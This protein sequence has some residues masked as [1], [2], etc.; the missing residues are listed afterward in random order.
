MKQKILILTLILLTILT[1][2]R[3][4]IDPEVDDFVEYGWTLY[5]ARDFRGALA[6]FQ[7]GL[8]LD[9]QYIDGYNGAGWCY[10]EFNSPDTAITYFSQGLDLIIVD[11]SQ[12]RF[13]MLAGIALSYHVTGDYPRAI[14]RG[15]EL[16]E[17][18]PVFE[19]VHN[20]RID[21]EEIIIM[22]ASSY[23][24]RGD[25]PASLEWVQVLDEEFTVD[26]TTNTGRAD[27]IKKIE[28]LQNI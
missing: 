22:L 18:R 14:S 5:D 15:E 27:L 8:A 13:E 17:F 9:P 10:V 16:I 25:F 7:A 26:V 2:C 4:K 3:E 12:V 6:Q 20:W 1:S 24:A 21:Y 28:T 11:S 19:F 23:F